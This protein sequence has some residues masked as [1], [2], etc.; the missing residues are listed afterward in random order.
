M[1][2]P[3]RPAGSAAALAIAAVGAAV[4]LVVAGATELSPDEAYYLAAS[5]F[6]PIPDHPP[7][8]PWLVGLSDRALA[9]VP[10][11][12]RVR[13]PAV[14]VSLACTLAVAALLRRQGASPRAQALGALLATWLPLPMAGGFIATPDGPALLA[15]VAVL[16]WSADAERRPWATLLVGP[17]VALGALA[18][19]VVVPLALVAAL[20]SGRP[21]RERAVPFVA[22][23]AVTPWLLPSLR[24]QLR[25]AYAA[26]AWSP[27]GAAAAVGAFVGAAAL[28]WWP[29]LPTVRGTLA[30]APRAWRAVALATTALVLASALVRGVPPEPNWWT[31]A[32]LVLIVGGA[33]A[34]A[35]WPRRA[36]LGVAVAVVGLTGAA[37]VHAVRPWL[38]L[39]TRAD[40]TARLHG[41]RTA[42]P[43]L[44]SPGVGPYAAASER[45]AH[46][47]RC[48]EIAFFIKS[49]KAN[50]EALTSPS[51]NH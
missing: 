38:P 28:L 8:L 26:P 25:H 30:G 39:A 45:C 10:L 14:L 43:P 36:W 5:R 21:W 7:L 11:E 44:N 37:L 46:T 42:D 29:V 20:F 13:A 31:P 2:S 40:P 47:G 51:A 6:G 9:V 19:V 15:L 49:L 23:A 33:S 1:L 16:A 27:G 12:L 34:M 17:A 24:F 50:S 41:W 48:D 22:A 32:A 4:H 35:A 3:R 18:K